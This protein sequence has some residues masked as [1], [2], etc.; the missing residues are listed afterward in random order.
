MFCTRRCKG[1][2]ERASGVS[3]KI[4]NFKPEE[5]LKLAISGHTIKLMTWNRC[6]C[7]CGWMPRLETISSK[8]DRNLLIQTHFDDIQKIRNVMPGIVKLMGMF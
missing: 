2:F 8:N 3:E 7:S 4:I 6:I 5:E 1:I